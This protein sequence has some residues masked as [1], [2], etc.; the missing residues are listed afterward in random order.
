MPEIMQDISE[1]SQ[2]KRA[3]SQGFATILPK[4]G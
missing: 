1:N 3:M 2:T 4:L